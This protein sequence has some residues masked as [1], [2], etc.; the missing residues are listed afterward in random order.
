MLC[1]DEAMDELAMADSISWYGLLL[2][3][4]DV[5]ILRRASVFV[6]EGYME[7]EVGGGMHEV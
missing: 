7:K 1:L 2:E 6:S 3:R 5:H 4:E